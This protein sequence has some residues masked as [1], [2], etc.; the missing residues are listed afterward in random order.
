MLI[1][2]RGD[3]KLDP[4]TYE[5]RNATVIDDL[6]NADFGH[7]IPVTKALISE[8]KE[9]TDRIEAQWIYLEERRKICEDFEAER[10]KLSDGFSCTKEALLRDGL[11][12]WGTIWLTTEDFQAERRKLSDGFSYTEKVLLWLVDEHR[13][14]GENQEK[15]WETN[16]ET[17]ETEAKVGRPK[18]ISRG[19]VFREEESD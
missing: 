15:D 7:L 1:G 2:N 10:R 14:V 12:E 9:E 6:I 5:W 19:I 18:D 3:R 8:F 13:R 11:E 17:T 4:A 16:E